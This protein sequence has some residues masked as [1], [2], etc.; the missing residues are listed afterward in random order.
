MR[1]LIQPEKAD[2]ANFILLVTKQYIYANKCLGKKLCKYELEVKI[3][4]N[5]KYELYHAK[6]NNC[7][8]KYCKKWNRNEKRV[9][10][11]GTENIELYLQTYSN[12][13]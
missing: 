13:N 4:K 8:Y 6:K 9:F 3:E 2:V 12:V 5:R 1:N 10:D 11:D 7:M